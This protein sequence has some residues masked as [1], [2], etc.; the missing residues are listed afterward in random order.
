[1]VLSWGR[2]GGSF[3]TSGVIGAAGS[4]SVKLSKNISKTEGKDSLYLVGHII[5]CVF[6]L[7]R[8]LSRYFWSF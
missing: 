2:G 7:W 1:M 4:F 8:V 6:M 3:C 5:S